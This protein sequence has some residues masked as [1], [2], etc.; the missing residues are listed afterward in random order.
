[1]VTNTN[2]NPRL[3]LLDFRLPPRS[4]WDLLSSGVLRSV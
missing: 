2:Y 3:F 4:R 1:V